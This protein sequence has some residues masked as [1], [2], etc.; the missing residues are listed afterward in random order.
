MGDGKGDANP[1]PETL[2]IL[3][4]TV[5]EAKTSFPP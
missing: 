2:N 1:I 4:G 5:A 3:R